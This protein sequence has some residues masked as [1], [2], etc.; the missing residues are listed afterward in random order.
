M[1]GVYELGKWWRVKSCTQVGGHLDLMK[2]TGSV[3]I[4]AGGGGHLP[5]SGQ[6]FSSV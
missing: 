4:V 5:V 3:P 1:S 2:A 6:K